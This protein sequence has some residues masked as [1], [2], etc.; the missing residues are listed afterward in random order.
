MV[1]WIDTFNTNEWIE[2]EEMKARCLKNKEYINTVGFYVGSF[3]GYEVLSPQFTD[4]PDMI[5]FSGMI[6]IPKG[7][8]KKTERL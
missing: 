8:I 4:N 6:A 7:C 3:H 1:T 5:N 2:V